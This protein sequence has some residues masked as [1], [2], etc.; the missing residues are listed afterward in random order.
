M[1]WF[2]L[3]IIIGRTGYRSPVIS[4]SVTYQKKLN[5][6][7]EHVLMIDASFEIEALPGNCPF[8]KPASQ[9]SFGCV[10]LVKVC[11]CQIAN[12]SIPDKVCL[13]QIWLWYSEML[14]SSTSF[15]N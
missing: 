3:K 12:G 6:G 7:H 13:H 1:V 8:H 11:G 15:S 10:K 9:R 4:S 2:K 5:N 14:A